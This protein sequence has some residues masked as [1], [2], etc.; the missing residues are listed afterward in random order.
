MKHK[1]TAIET[2]FVISF[3]CPSIEREEDEVE[4][5]LQIYFNPCF[6]FLLFSFSLFADAGSESNRIGR[7]KK[8]E[9]VNCEV[10]EKVSTFVFL[11]QIIRT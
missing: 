7:R 10:V 5:F 11:Q 4:K 8:I 9:T 1:K 2:F 6:P 3:S